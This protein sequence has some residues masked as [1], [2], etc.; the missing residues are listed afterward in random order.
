MIRSL[1]LERWLKDL[2]NKLKCTGII[3]IKEFSRMQGRFLMLR[4][5]ATK[6]FPYWNIF[7]TLHTV[8]FMHGL[9]I[10]EIKR[11]CHRAYFFRI[12]YWSLQHLTNFLEIWNN[13]TSPN[14]RAKTVV[15]F[16]QLLSF[17]LNYCAWPQTFK[18]M[19]MFTCYP[20]L[21]QDTAW[22]ILA[23]RRKMEFIFRINHVLKIWYWKSWKFIFN[24]WTIIIPFR[25]K[26]KNLGSPN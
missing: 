25:K 14:Y 6:Y 10:Y 4:T 18:K 23:I 26:N 9:S 19:C 20:M 5:Y 22:Y 13:N 21:W 2:T 17:N 24:S 12:S 11:I 3:G 15:I 7:N 8:C 1:D 16:S